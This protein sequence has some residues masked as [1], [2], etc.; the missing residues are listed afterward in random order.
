M[1]VMSLVP[2]ITA[3]I[4]WLFLGEVMNL[5]EI[6]AMLVDDLRSGQL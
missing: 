6:L 4:G 1:L 5:R 2:L 3:V